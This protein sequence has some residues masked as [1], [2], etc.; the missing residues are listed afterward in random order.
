MGKRD[1]DY[2]P[3]VNESSIGENQPTYIGTY[4]VDYTYRP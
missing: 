3:N 2:I 4:T 1:S